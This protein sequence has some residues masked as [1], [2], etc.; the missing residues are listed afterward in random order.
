MTTFGKVGNTPH[1]PLC[2]PVDRAFL[3]HPQVDGPEPDQFVCMICD[4][5]LRVRADEAS[6]CAKHEQEA[7][8]NAIVGLIPGSAEHWKAVLTS[9]NARS[10]NRALDGAISAIKDIP[11]ADFNRTNVLF[12]IDDQRWN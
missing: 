8:A 10:R 3:Q 7:V 2:D 11:D 6:N 1:D 4:L 12:A 9:T 5:I